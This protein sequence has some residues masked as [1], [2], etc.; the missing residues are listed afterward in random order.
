MTPVAFR[1]GRWGFDAEVARNLLRLGYRIDTSIT[2]YTILGTG[3][4]PGLFECLSSTLYVD[5]GTSSTGRIPR[6]ALA[7]IPVSIGY[8]YGD[9]QACAKLSQRLRSGSLRGLK[10]GRSSL[11]ISCAAKGVAL[12][13]N[14]D[15]R[16]HDSARAADEESGL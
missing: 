8:L 13:R 6:G 16:E 9:F 1:S 11:K 14:G 12:S 15:A 10:L 7:E 3:V 5:A 4:W 2:P